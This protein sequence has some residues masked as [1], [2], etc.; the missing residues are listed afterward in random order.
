MDSER[1]LYEALK[2]NLESS[3]SLRKVRAEVKSEIMKVF[4]TNPQPRDKPE[5]PESLLLI[6]SLIQEY[7]EWNGYMYTSQILADESGM[8]SKTYS[9]QSMQKELQVSEDENT[10]KLPLLC[11]LVSTFKEAAGKISQ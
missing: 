2:E 8:T 3:G 6:N 7:L 9:R 1:E 5:L 10:R 4:D 11:S